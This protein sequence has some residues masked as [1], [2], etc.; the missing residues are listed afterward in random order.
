[1][2]WI[3]IKRIALVTAVLA[4]LGCIA[5]WS[6]L[7]D[8]HYRPQSRWL[9]PAEVET[10]GTSL[11]TVA[12]TVITLEIVSPLLELRVSACW[13]MLAFRTR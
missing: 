1:M 10:L 12:P 6:C 11:V 13:V 3:C 7:E 9:S 2:N 5:V 8:L 4:E